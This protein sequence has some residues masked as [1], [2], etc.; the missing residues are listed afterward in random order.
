VPPENS[1]EYIQE[2]K[3]KIWKSIG[4]RMEHTHT[5]AINNFIIYRICIYIY[6]GIIFTHNKHCLF[7][8]HCLDS[9]SF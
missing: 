5:Y 3:K 8:F 1:E 4:Q 7:F 2:R 9:D 6:I